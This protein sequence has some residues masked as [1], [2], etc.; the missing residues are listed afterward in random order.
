MIEWPFSLAPD[1][2]I[3]PGVWRA[4]SRK[5]KKNKYLC[6]QEA[7]RRRT[8]CPGVLWRMT[9][10]HILKV[11]RTSILHLLS[12]I[13]VPRICPGSRCSLISRD[14]QIP[15]NTRKKAGHSSAVHS[16]AVSVWLHAIRYPQRPAM[17]PATGH[18]PLTN[19]LSYPPYYHAGNRILKPTVG[20]TRF[21]YFH[22]FGLPIPL[23]T[24]K[25]SPFPNFPKSAFSRAPK[26]L[27]L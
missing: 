23:P 25:D 22:V 17:P 26:K 12:S 9:R 11:M 24:N 16:L 18:G 13:V 27:F 20:L 2:C 5:N 6:E 8:I 1:T 19:L 4:K 10:E 7:N 21:F 15:A 3:V 14:A